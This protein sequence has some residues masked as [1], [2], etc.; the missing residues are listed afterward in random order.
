MDE[1]NET[2]EQMELLIGKENA[3]KVIDFFEG[4]SIYFPKSIGLAELH[5]RIYA[6]LRNGATYKR[7]A[8]KYGYTKSYIRRIEKKMRE[9]R[10]AAR[11]GGTAKPSAFA[12]RNENAEKLKPRD[13]KPFEQGEL[14]YE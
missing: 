5:G 4:S 2:Y 8:Q 9:A 3:R 1:N 12:V 6:E 7:L 13:I 11:D 14:F 10:K